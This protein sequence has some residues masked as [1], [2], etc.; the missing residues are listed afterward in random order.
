MGSTEVLA[1]GFV[2]AFWIAAIAALVVWNVRR[3]RRRRRQESRDR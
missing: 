3:D 2:V 1:V